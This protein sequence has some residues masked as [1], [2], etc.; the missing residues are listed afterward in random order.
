MIATL[1]FSMVINILLFVGP[2]YMLQVYDRVLSTRSLSTLFVVSV[3]AVAVVCLSGLIDFAR[4]RILVRV[5][6][7]FDQQLS[8]AVFDKVVAAELQNAKGGSWQNLR[9]LDALREFVTGSAL[10]TLFDAPWSPLFILLCFLF[11]PIIGFVALVGAIII[12]GLAVLN[13]TLVTRR[14]K[15][16]YSITHEA[17]TFA[18]FALRNKEVVHALGMRGAVKNRWRGMHNDA[19]GWQSVAS[20]HGG[21]I[22]AISKGVRATLQLAILGVGAMLAIEREISPGTMIAASIL[23]GR[24]LQPI[25]AAVGQWRLFVSARDAYGRL[26]ELFAAT[27]AAPPAMRLPDPEGHL[28]LRDVSIK[29]PG[30]E[31][32]TVENVSFDVRPGEIVAIIGPVASGKTTLLRGIVGIWETCQGTVSID[33]AALDQWDPERLGTFIGYL[34]QDVEL[35]GGTVAENIARLGP[36]DEEAVVQAAKAAGIHGMI[37]GLP[38][39]YDANVGMGGTGLSGGQRQAVALARALYRNPRLIVLDEPNSNLDHNGDVNLM[40]AL[41]AARA[42]GAAVVVS[43]HRLPLLQ[44]VDRIV[45]MMNGRLQSYGPRNDILAQ[46]GKAPAA[47]ATPNVLPQAS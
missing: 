26:K 7:S 21:T 16:A 15:R 27:P 13:E 40:N 17:Q 42:N 10:I 41:Q 37:A 38:G 36:I 39:G 22:L 34:P 45:V 14:L 44:C 29:P 33:G 3:A 1:L 12:V 23:M 6:V 11:H 24:A 4:S 20:D 25:E 31:K 8:H 28:R 47:P 18:N 35:F 32:P 2:V 43:T 9:D 5:G 30:A 46:L 19:L